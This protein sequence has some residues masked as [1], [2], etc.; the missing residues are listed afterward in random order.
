VRNTVPLWGSKN[1]CFEKGGA[2]SKDLFCS[3]VLSLWLL[4]Q[5]NNDHAAPYTIAT[6]HVIGNPQTKTQEILVKV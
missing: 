3:I 5:L 6:P 4:S 1:F 2:K